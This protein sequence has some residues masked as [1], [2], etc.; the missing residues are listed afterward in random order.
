M[1]WKLFTALDQEWAALS[2]SARARRTVTSWSDDP[3][4]EGFDDPAAIVAALRAGRRDPAAANRVLAGLARRAPF[5]DLAARTLLQALIPG[6][7]NVAKRIGRGIID[8]ELEAQVLTEAVDRIRNYPLERR[9]RAIA[10]NVTMDVFHRASRHAAATM[11]LID[12]PIAADPADDPSAE[13]CAIVQ[14]ALDRG[15]IRPVDA[16]LLLSIAV[17]H[18]T[19]TSR[20]RREGVSYEAMNERWRRARNRLRRAAA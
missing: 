14:D 3:A 15:R 11:Q 18:D 20:A 19:I 17:G 1:G 8:E 12:E 6:L 5:D 13:V 4:L 2:R 9:P 10:A 16:D 7:V